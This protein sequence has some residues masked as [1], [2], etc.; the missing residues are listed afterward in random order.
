MKSANVTPIFKAESGGNQET[1]RP[2]SITSVPAILEGRHHKSETYKTFV[3]EPHSEKIS[4]VSAIR[5]RV[6][7]IWENLFE[8][9]NQQVDVIYLDFQKALLKNPTKD[10]NL[11]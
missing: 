1:K 11:N 6:F 3:N 8:K 2:V 4:M 10:L 7:P 9:V 5:N